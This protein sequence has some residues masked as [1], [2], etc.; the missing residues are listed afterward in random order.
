MKMDMPKYIR[1]EYY[2]FGNYVTELPNFSEYEAWGHSEK[3]AFVDKFVC[4]EYEDWR[5]WEVV[6]RC[7]N[8]ARDMIDFLKGE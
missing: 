4:E 5:N 7:A 2:F 1:L 6:E 8:D 3:L